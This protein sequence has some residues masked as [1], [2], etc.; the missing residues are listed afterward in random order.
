[1]DRFLGLSG[2]N[3]IALH[4]AKVAGKQSHNR[5]A[6]P[7]KMIIVS[8]KHAFLAILPQLGPA[9]FR[10]NWG[11]DPVQGRCRV[12]G[13]HAQGRKQENWILT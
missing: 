9:D 5:P 7:H 11:L 12:P 2:E 8:L 1:M 10:T 6:L 13:A 4:G 3:P